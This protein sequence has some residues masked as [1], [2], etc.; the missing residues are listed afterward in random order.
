LKD[1]QNGQTY[2]VYDGY[3]YPFTQTSSAFVTRF[4]IH[5]VKN[6]VTGI[7]NIDDYGLSI[8]PN[9][10]F[11]KVVLSMG[12][13]SEFDV[14]ISDASGKIIRCEKSFK[15]SSSLDLSGI[16]AGVYFVSAS[17]NG[18]KSFHKLVKVSGAQ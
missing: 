10:A 6:L 5:F 17:H 16:N 18:V 7:S 14:E 13:V 2:P 11:D 4:E 1:L 3:Q 8:Y 12:Y 9:P 15:S